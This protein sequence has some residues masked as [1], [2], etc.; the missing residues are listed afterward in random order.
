[1]MCDGNLVHV[2]PALQRVEPPA[3]AISRSV[4]VGHAGVRVKE[5]F[6]QWVC[7]S[8]SRLR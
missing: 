1:M 2:H 8:L 5:W 4:D 7:D 3:E 6:W